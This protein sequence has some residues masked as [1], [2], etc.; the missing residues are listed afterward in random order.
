MFV[1]VEQ[2]TTRSDPR[3]VY[4]WTEGTLVRALKRLKPRLQ[5][6]EV[7]AIVD[8]A[9]RHSTWSAKSADPVEL[10]LF[11]EFA[12]LER[13]ENRARWVRLLWPVSIGIVALVVLA[14]VLLDWYLV[15][16]RQLL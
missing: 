16:T 9:V 13:V 10:A 11:A 8:V 12:D 1:A 2:I 7:A 5:P 3:D 15:P 4:I 6:D 14:P